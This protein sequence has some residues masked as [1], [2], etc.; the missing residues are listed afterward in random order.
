MMLIGRVILSNFMNIQSSF[1]VAK[2]MLFFELAFFLYHFFV[3]IIP[4]F[5]LIVEK[6]LYLCAEK[7]RLS[8]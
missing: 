5:L 1:V 2:V 6:T 4:F 3:K 8:F 7:P